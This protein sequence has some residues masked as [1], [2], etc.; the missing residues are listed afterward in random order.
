MA[1]DL[2]PWVIINANGLYL[3]LH[4][5]PGAK[6]SG[7]IGTYGQALKVAVHARAQDG[8]ANAELLIIIAQACD[9]RKAD[10]KLCSGAS[11]R[12]KRVF[13]SGDAKVLLEGLS[14]VHH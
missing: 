12:K 14:N 9:V 13:V 5:Q 7:I 4:I 6:R 2:P 10:I 3:Q 11:S 8:K 1:M